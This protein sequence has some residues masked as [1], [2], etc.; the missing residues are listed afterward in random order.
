[1]RAHWQQ[2]VRASTLAL[3][4]LAAVTFSVRA[5]GLTDQQASSES[6]VRMS[7][8]V[9][10]APLSDT[11]VYSLYLPIVTRQPGMLYGTVTEYGLPA[12]DVNVTLQRCLTWFTNPGG[13]LVCL[14]RDTY[15]AIT[16]RHGWY[17]FID[18]PSLVIS[19]GE[20]YSQTYQAHWT[21]A[22]SAPDRLA[23]WD[24][25]IIKSYAQGD[26]VNL[27]NFDIGGIALLAPTA[28][29][30]VHFPVTFQWVPRH[31]M[32]ADNY[33]VCV[34]GGMIIPRYVWGDLVCFD[35]LGHTNQVVMDSP[36]AGIDYGYGYVWYV[37]V[38]DNTGGI[39][40]SPSV[41]FRFAPP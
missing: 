24:S 6:L 13:N 20:Y 36:F 11:L 28:G 12:A 40:H 5:S 41:P 29:A 14:T 23:G 35:S 31:N 8:Q 17:A 2:A 9:S 19:P 1:M 7:S 22:A 27:G 33:R 16:D 25:R 10:A 26:I 3:I 38:P 21:N 32:P 34:S 18:L 30:V 15:A 39:G 37:I 4:G